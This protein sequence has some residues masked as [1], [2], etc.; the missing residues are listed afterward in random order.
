MRSLEFNDTAVYSS[1]RSSYDRKIFKGTGHQK[2]EVW[3]GYET[4]NSAAP[5]SHMSGGR[6]IAALSIVTLCIQR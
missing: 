4:A 1:S 3:N 5:A 6:S 2:E